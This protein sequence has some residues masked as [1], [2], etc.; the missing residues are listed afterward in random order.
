MKILI[1]GIDGYL[2]WPLALY[3]TEKGYEVTGVDC[4][5]KRDWENQ[6]DGHPL[7]A[8]PSL[9]SRVKTAANLNYPM[10]VYHVDIALES[11]ALYDIIGSVKPDAIIH[12]AEQPS[13]PYSME[14]RSRAVSTQMNNVIGTLNLLFAVKS[15]CP[16]C[17][18]IKLGTMGEYGT[19]NIDIEEGWLNIKHNDRE[20]RVLYPKKPGSFY[21][22]SKVHDSA[23]LEFACRIWDLRVTDLN[24]GVVWGINP[25]PIMNHVG[26]HTSFHYD[27]TFGTVINRFITQAVAGEP[28]T[29]YGDGSQTR[30]FIHIMDTLRCIELAMET[31]AGVGEFRVFNQFTEQWSVRNLAEIVASNMVGST[32]Q[33]VPNPRV[34]QYNHYYNAKN[35]GL[36][37]LGLDPIR[38][39]PE[40]I[41][42]IINYV[43]MYNTNINVD[44][45]K[46]TIK[47]RDV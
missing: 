6:V 42:E 38:M 28:L 15:Q 23:N 3:L 46:P 26:M 16:D 24:Q 20:D 40:T 41:K 36:L 13:A 1:L 39:S 4:S 21:H 45:F 17:H 7:V 31:P 33:M 35:D 8:L 5:I 44:Y 10:D 32:Y 22:L 9:T 34:E 19:P 37:N 29:I 30:G 25:L 18:I 14:N 11:G 47:W 43:S 27:S 2:G 12:L